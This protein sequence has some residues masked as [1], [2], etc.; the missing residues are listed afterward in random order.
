VWPVGAPG[1]PGRWRSTSR[2]TARV[3]H[4]RLTLAE[5]ARL[6][7]PLDGQLTL[8]GSEALDHRWVAVFAKNAGPDEG[9]E[10]GDHATL[11]VRPGKLEDRGALAGSGVLP[12]LADLN[13]CQVR[14]TVWVGM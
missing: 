12:N 10:L 1:R 3:N 13:G 9:G 8:K 4:C 11:R 2:A 14:R 6:P 5:D 7:V